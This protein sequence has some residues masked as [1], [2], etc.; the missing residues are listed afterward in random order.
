M[1][2]FGLGLDETFD[3]PLGI[4][5]MLLRQPRGLVFGGLTTGDMELMEHQ[6]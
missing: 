5:D 4:L 6:D 2:R 1:E 3:M